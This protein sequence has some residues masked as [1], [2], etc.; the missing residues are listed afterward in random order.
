M[1]K[2]ISSSFGICTKLS[3]GETKMN[4]IETIE[5]KREMYNNGKCFYYIDSLSGNMYTAKDDCEI[6]NVDFDAMRYPRLQSC[7]KMLEAEKR[8]VAQFKPYAQRQHEAEQKAF[9]NQIESFV[10]KLKAG[11]RVRL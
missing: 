8:R 10:L 7:L 4:A 2:R 9:E 1:V 11:E 5:R 3:R 6:M